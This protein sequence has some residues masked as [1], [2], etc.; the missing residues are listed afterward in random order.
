M[1]TGQQHTRSLHA[2]SA[3]M[4][5]ATSFLYIQTLECPLRS[6]VRTAHVEVS[7]P[8]RQ[9][10]LERTSAHETTP[11]IVY[12]WV[13]NGSA[14]IVP[15]R[16]R[17]GTRITVVLPP[18]SRWRNRL[19]HDLRRQ[20]EDRRSRP[21]DARKGAASANTAGDPRGS[22]ARRG[23]IRRLRAAN[24]SQSARRRSMRAG[25]V[26]GGCWRERS[27]PGVVLTGHDTGMGRV[28]QRDGAGGS[29]PCGDVRRRTG[30]RRLLRS[31][32][33][34]VPGRLAEDEQTRRVL[35]ERQRGRRR[36]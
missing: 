15:W 9:V 2:V 23:G 17:S 22:G 26:S 8:Q 35:R 3:P 7:H 31:E 16:A 30:Q 12:R 32:L 5:Q 10:S 21:V 4:P 25:L 28:K 14:S 33:R 6:Q 11:D 19:R 20:S 27:A 34:S 1:A 13:C 24:G 18:R 29:Q 36:L